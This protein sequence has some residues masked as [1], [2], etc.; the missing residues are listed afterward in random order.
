MHAHF[1]LHRLTAGHPGLA[2]KLVH[3]YGNADLALSEFDAR[4]TPLRPAMA[5]SLTETRNTAEHHRALEADLLWAEQ[6]SRHVLTVSDAA[7]PPI[8]KTLS[9]P[10]FLLF[11]WG[12]PR[13]LSEEQMAIVG[14]RKPTSTGLSVASQMSAE[15]A[16]LGFTIT[17]GLAY[18]IDAM[19]HRG[20]LDAGGVTIA[21]Q[22][23]GADLIYPRSHERLA[24]R[25]LQQGC[26]VTEY[27]TGFPAHARHF[28]QRNRIVTG[29]CRGTLV[30]EAAAKSGSLISA[31]LAMEQGREVFAVPGSIH[32]R[33]SEGCHQLIRQGATLVTSVAD[34]VEEFHDFSVDRS[35]R[36]VSFSL[37]E[38]LILAALDDGP[39]HAD[40][41]HEVTAVPVPELM[42]DLMGLEIKGEISSGP[43]G[44]IKCRLS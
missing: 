34:L 44:Y 36:Q 16:E 14:S 2:Q 29:L 18:G 10:P 42:A 31:R 21:V 32:S 28:P 22:G 40:R 5:R 4:L 6:D 27:P 17:S 11:V 1:S 3:F 26:L 24:L 35:K 41:L 15:L 25:V 19:A 13:Y 9:D 7:Y 43:E 12:D 33:Q 23:C 30:I 8:L 38:K 20:A 37:T 39:R